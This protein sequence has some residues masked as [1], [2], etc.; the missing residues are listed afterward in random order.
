V[1]SASSGMDAVDRYEVLRG[2]SDGLDP[3]L[4]RHRVIFSTAPIMASLLTGV[5]T[6][7]GQP[8]FTCAI[9]VAFP[10]SRRRCS[11]R[12]NTFAFD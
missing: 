3:I 9:G 4:V 6:V 8:A 12:L 1:R 5:R 2:S 11:N 7:R 10:V